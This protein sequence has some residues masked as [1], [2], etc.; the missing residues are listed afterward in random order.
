MPIKYAPTQKIMDRSTKKMSTKNFYMHTIPTRQLVS[1]IKEARLTPKRLQKIRHELTRRG[2][3]KK[4]A[5]LKK[6]WEDPNW[7]PVFD[8]LFLASA[9]E[10]T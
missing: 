3:T 2:V 4:Q 5:W 1:D 9:M 8:S 7:D 10:K 6:P